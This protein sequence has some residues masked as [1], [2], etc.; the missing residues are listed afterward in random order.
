MNR[1]QYN[2]V[3]KGAVK[4]VGVTILCCLPALVLLGFWLQEINKAARMA[5]FVV[6]MLVVICIVEYIHIKLVTKRQITKKILHK[7]Q[8]VF[9]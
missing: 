1:Q 4:R 8:D 5:I 9:K 7:N 3:L 2:D 6:F